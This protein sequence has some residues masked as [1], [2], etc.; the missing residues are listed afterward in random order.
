MSVAY[1]TI[2]NDQPTERHL[3]AVSFSCANSAELHETLTAEGRV[4]M[5][6]LAS[7]VIPALGS[8]EFAPGHKH[9]MV[10]GLKTDA[11]C[12]VK[13]VFGADEAIFTLPIKTRE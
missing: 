9:I 4:S 2:D 11:E 12:R 7:V 13:F 3:V 10:F 6:R 5:H 1:G 8:I